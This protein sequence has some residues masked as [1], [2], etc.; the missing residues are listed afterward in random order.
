[1]RAVENLFQQ[2]RLLS[3]APSVEKTAQSSG[4]CR[5]GASFDCHAQ[6]INPLTNVAADI[7]ATRRNNIQDF[8]FWQEKN[9]E[10]ARKINVTSGFSPGTELASTK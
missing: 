6:N 3:F 10:E 8:S 5:G 7:S 4:A 1:L 2:E 9:D